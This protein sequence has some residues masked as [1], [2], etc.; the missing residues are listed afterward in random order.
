MYGT[1]LNTSGTQRE[2]IWSTRQPEI[3]QLVHEITKAIGNPDV[4]QTI[5]NVA[6]AVQGD[7]IQQYGSGSVGKAQHSGSGSI[8]GS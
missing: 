3:Q 7:F 4:A 5:I 8:G 6:H 1:V 2:A